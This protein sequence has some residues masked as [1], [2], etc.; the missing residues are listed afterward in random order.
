[1]RVLIVDDSRSMRSILRRIVAPLGFAEIAEAEHGADAL[2]QVGEQAP[3]LVLVDWNMPVMGGQ[4]FIVELR[5]DRA[6]DRVKVLVVSSESSAR[7]VMDALRA[8][9]DEYAM[10]PV[11]ADVIS[12]KLV[13][14]GLA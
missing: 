4:E 6:Y 14:M 11:T 9:A 2:A 3:E 12:D 10:K 1:M 5:K 7:I 13:L 8:G